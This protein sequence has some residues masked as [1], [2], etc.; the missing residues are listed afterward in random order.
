MHFQGKNGKKWAKMGI[1]KAKMA[2]IGQK[3]AFSRQ[4]WQKLGKNVH[5]QGKNAK[6]GQKWAFSQQKWPRIG[7]SKAK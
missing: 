2:K 1:F 6:N 7:I 4:K 3:G 5:F